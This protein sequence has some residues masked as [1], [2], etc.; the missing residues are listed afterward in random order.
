MDCR[1]SVEAALTALPGTIQ[2]VVD[3]PSQTARILFDR[4]VV[5][6]DALRAALT[7]ASA[8]SSTNIPIDEI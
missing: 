2:V 8:V 3:L 6:V 4:E 7:Q 1:A 5:D